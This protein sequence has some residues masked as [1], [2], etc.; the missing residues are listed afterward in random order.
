VVNFL[1]VFFE[2]SVRTLKNTLPNTIY[3][4][5][6]TV[7]LLFI[8]HKWYQKASQENYQMP[9]KPIQCLSKCYTGE[10]RN[11]AKRTG[12]FLYFSVVKAPTNVLWLFHVFRTAVSPSILF[13][14][15]SFANIY[16]YFSSRTAYTQS[17]HMKCTPFHNLWTVMQ[18]NLN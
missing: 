10:Q 8:Y 14:A 15:T 5:H 7:T 16:V 9:L 2:C 12:A 3:K 6:H 11:T 17:V 4:W 18:R 1:M 13:T